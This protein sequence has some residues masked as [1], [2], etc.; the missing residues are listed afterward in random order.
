MRH[1]LA[2]RVPGWA[3]VLTLWL[4]SKPA[5][6]GRREWT[7]TTAEQSDA[8]LTLCFCPTASK[9]GWD[10]YHV[11]SILRTD[12]ALLVVDTMRSRGGFI[13]LDPVTRESRLARAFD[14]EYTVTV[15]T[16]VMWEDATAARPE[17]ISCVS[18]ARRMAGITT[19]GIHTPDQLLDILWRMRDE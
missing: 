2:C 13:P 18:M 17:P 3:Q 10:R 6:P 14:S 1:W 5:K 15:R 12:Q 9:R 8:T 7:A 11:V 19:P 4:A 16:R